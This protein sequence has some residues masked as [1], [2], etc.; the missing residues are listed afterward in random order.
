MRELHSETRKTS[1]LIQRQ[2]IACKYYMH[3]TT[4]KE[5]IQK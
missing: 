5:E 4:E 1:Q 3:P 2:R